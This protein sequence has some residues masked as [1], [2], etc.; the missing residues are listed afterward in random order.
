MEKLN[1][2]NILI[3]GGAGFIGSSIVKYLIGKVN[4]IRILDNLSTGKMDNI[5]SIISDNVE[6]MYG[7][8]NNLDVCRNAMKNIDIICHQAALGSVPRS[9]VDPMTTHI[10]NVTGFV[11]VLI[12]A[13]ENNIKR[14][15]YASSS[16]VYGDS[17]VLPKKE[18][19]EGNLLSPYAASKYIDEIYAQVFNKCYNMECIGL[20]YF[21]VFGPNQDPNGVYAAVIPKFINLICNDKS[22]IIN[23]DGS[24]S[25][26]FTF[27]DNI[28]YANVQSMTCDINESYNMV[29]NIGTGSSIT[30]NE[31]VNKIKTYLNKDTS[32][33]YGELRDGDIPHSNANI[34]LAMKDIKYNI[35]TNF[36]DGLIKTIN[37]FL[38]KN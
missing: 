29:Y 18:G 19:D 22:P 13:K 12:A 11:N 6:F 33:I 24:F 4:Y 37:Y 7:D 28:I 31:L 21:N 17:V 20:R 14:I 38:N 30:L 25:R 2:K 35:I 26:D 16:A 8:I 9:I 27:I 32:I 1:N 3:T 10:S 15:V 5:K 34:S 36:D 23:G